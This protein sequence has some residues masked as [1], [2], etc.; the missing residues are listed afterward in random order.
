[1]DEF[2]E[3]I[4][5]RLR[6]EQ[7]FVRVFGF[8]SRVGALAVWPFE[9][10][11]GLFMRL[12]V[13]GVER[14][15]GADFFLFGVL[16]WLLAPFR[17]LWYLC[18]SS[19]AIMR[20]Y[21]IWPIEKLLMSAM[22]TVFGAIEATEDRGH[23]FTQMRWVVALWWQKRQ[24]TAAESSGAVRLLR[25]IMAAPFQLIGYLL[26]RLV[27]AFLW[28]AER[29]NLD[30]VL[31]RLIYWTRPLWYPVASLG[32]FVWS[33]FVTRNQWQLLWGIPLLAVLLP[34]GWVLAQNVLWGK[35]RIADQYRAAVALAREAK[36][37]DR[38]QLYERKLA[39]LGV[40]TDAT[41]FN[42]A[43]GLAQDG[44]FDDAYERMSAIAPTDHPGYA[45]AHL[46]IIQQ[47]LMDRIKISPEK[48]NALIAAHFQQLAT[49]GLKGAEIDLLRAFWLTRG[50]KP[51]EAADLLAPLVHSHPSAAIERMRLDALLGRTSDARKDA[52]IVEDFMDQAKRKNKP[53]T[54]DDYQAWCAA[55]DVLSHTARLQSI[56][57]EWLKVDAA[58]KDA[59]EI[60]SRLRVQRLTQSLGDSAANL[61]Q[62]AADIRLVL[63]NQVVSPEVRKQI[64]DLY[65]QR[66]VNPSFKKAFDQ[67][68]QANG[69]PPTL[70]D[71][72][73]MAAAAEDDW[74][75]AE[76][77]L[78]QVVR[79][80]PNNT[81]AWNNL[82]YVI[83]K[84][85]GDLQHALTAATAA[86][87]SDANN[88]HFRETRGQIL[89][90]LGR[91]QDAIDDLE[92][93]VNGIPNAPAIHAALAQAYEAIGNTDLAA[94]HRQSAQ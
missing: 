45:N 44:N 64:F 91:W 78:E 2:P 14:I 51:A 33:W 53:L 37:F 70:A 58:N 30:G 8:F 54:S 74:A 38:L 93:A 89:V 17:W 39:Q 24:E 43:M 31:A 40:N 6:L 7:M 47:V 4:P 12:M 13:G 11:L 10:C 18:G 68:V 41:T 5:W 46:W 52:A 29:L 15:E 16:W 79:E 63:A 90:K 56:A 35:S 73:G 23:V 71:V 67:L 69:L 42:T 85:N 27:H 28:T 65:R 92:F 59:Q 87:K 88:F 19:L 66:S 32:G 81:A 62:I 76:M 49:L 55:E 60:Q 72:L 75:T 48:S 84:R 94:S 9:F 21:F 3:N 61:D 26:F 77:L 57:D 50:N 86:V 82:A 25:A 1:M 20:D 22:R 36:T 80:L 83:L 34:A